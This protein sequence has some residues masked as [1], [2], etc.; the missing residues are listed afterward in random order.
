VAKPLFVFVFSSDF[1]GSAQIFMIYLLLISSRLLFPQ[2]VAV[3]LGKNKVLLFISV[4]ELA[5]NVGLSLLLLKPFGLEGI[6]MAT[7]VAFMLD[8][9]LIAAYLYYNQGISPK[10]YTPLPTY[11]FWL[12]ML[13]LTYIFIRIVF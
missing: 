1:E 2:T 7:V 11:F 4:I 12:L 9:I 10:R 8:K 6:A 5:V 13:L 3:G